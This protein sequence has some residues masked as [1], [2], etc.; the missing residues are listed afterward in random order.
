[1]TAAIA[2]PADKPVTNT[3]RPVNAERRYGVLDHL[4]DRERL[5]MAASNVAR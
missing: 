1:M 3:L 2:P 5:A 4:L